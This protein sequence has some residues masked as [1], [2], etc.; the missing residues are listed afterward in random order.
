MK[1]IGTFSE[2]V[3]LKG[4][5]VEESKSKNQM[6]GEGGDVILMF[7][8]FKKNALTYLYSRLLFTLGLFYWGAFQGNNF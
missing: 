1:M 6:R 5:P 8:F 7:F 4:S 3:P 2:V